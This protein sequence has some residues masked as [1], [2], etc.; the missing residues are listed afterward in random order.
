MGWLVEVHL[1]SVVSLFSL[2]WV[3]IELLERASK[4]I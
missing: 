3:Y 4:A 2:G 1:A